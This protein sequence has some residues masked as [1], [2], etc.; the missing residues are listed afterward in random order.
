VLAHPRELDESSWRTFLLAGL[1]FAAIAAVGV[2][3]PH[4][5]AWPLAVVATW[6]ALSYVI[7]AWRSAR[8]R[9]SS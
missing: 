6:L 5:I 3:W 8:K 7:R 1:L 2:R 9:A 4:A